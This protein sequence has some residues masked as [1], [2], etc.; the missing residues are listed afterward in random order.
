MHELNHPFIAP[1]TCIAHTAT[2]LLPYYCAIFASLPTAHFHAIHHTI[3]CITISCK[4][5]VV[6]VCLS[7]SVCVY[8]SVSVGLWVSVCMCVWLYVSVGVC[9]CLCVCVCVWHEQHNSRYRRE[10]DF[11]VGVV[12]NRCHTYIPIYRVLFLPTTHRSWPFLISGS[13]PLLSLTRPWVQPPVLP[14][15]RLR[16]VKR[17]TGHTHTHT[18]AEQTTHTTHEHR[19]SNGATARL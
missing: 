4:G 8:V 16:F 14:H 18:T 5:E 3:L 1:P 2:I 6:C 19:A 15:S 7:V 11:A 12:V 17:S 9:L 10:P 13:V